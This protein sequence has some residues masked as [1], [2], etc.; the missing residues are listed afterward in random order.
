M[1]AWGPGFRSL[2]QWKKPVSTGH[3]LAGHGRVIVTPILG[4][5]H[6]EYRLKEEAA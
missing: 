2:A 4:G 5:L 3:R 1:A 6:H